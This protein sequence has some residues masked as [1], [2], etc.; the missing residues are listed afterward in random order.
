MISRFYLLLV[1]ILLVVSCQKDCSEINSDFQSYHEAVITIK[2]TDF[3]LEEELTK[4]NSS[5]IDNAE[6]Y[7]C[8]NN[9]GFMIL[10]TD[11]GEYIYQK[12]PLSIWRNFQKANSK[13]RFYNRH[14]KG[15]YQL[16]IRN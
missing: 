4:N 7:S 9:F 13:G 2:N 1:T 6:Y 14:I 12:M 16:N 10:Y 8:D 5:W 11:G 15:K 3:H